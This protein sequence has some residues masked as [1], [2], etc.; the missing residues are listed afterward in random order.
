M[1]DLLDG[2]GS[3]N[4][5]GR[6]QYLQTQGQALHQDILEGA[7]VQDR[8]VMTVLD[9]LER[10]CGCCYPSGFGSVECDTL[11]RIPKQSA[12]LHRDGIAMHELPN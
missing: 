11:Q 12:Y 4:H 10:E 7:K 5:A 8:T 2:G 1:L 9:N 3:A 6:I